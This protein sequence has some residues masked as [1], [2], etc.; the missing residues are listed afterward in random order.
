VLETV[1][2]H[3]LIAEDDEMQAELLRRYLEHDGHTI[4]VVHNG[5]AAIDEVR[6]RQ[7]RICWC[8]T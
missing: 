7:N 8:S 5:R 3:V 1:C 2:A 4:A 6:V